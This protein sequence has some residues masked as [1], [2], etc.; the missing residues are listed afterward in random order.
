MPKGLAQMLSEADRKA[1]VAVGLPFDTWMKLLTDDAQ[2][3]RTDQAIIAVVQSAMTDY[4]TA[5][6]I[7]E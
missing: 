3:R 1:I 6:E 2:G 4:A 7:K 5:H